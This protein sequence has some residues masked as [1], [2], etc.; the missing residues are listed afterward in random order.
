MND[1]GAATSGE[2]PCTS[3]SATDSNGD[4]SDRKGL[5]EQVLGALDANN[6]RQIENGTNVSYTSNQKNL[7]WYID[8]PLGGERMV[9]APTLLGGRLV[10]PTLVPTSDACDGGGFSMIVAVD[11]FSGKKTVVNI[12]DYANTGTINYD[13]FKLAVGV[14]KNVVPASI[15]S[16][17]DRRATSRSSRRVP[18]SR[19]AVRCVAASRGGKS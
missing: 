18:S 2:T 7:G 13:S 15:F 4:K 10:F 5:Q 8:L 14:V 3:P 17:A 19:P 9:T 16:P 6:R 1:P 12:F 11:P